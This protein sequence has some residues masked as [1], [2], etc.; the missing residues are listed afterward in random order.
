[1]KS[2]AGEPSGSF[3]LLSEE[4]WTA[5]RMEYSPPVVRNAAGFSERRNGV[6]SVESRQ[7]GCAEADLALKCR[8]AIRWFTARL[9][10]LALRR[11]GFRFDHATGR[12][13]G[14]APDFRDI[15]AAGALS[16]FYDFRHVKWSF[17]VFDRL[18][19]R[20]PSTTEPRAED[21]FNLPLPFWTSNA[22][23]D[24]PVMWL[25]TDAASLSK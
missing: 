23:V 21:P 22:G 24:L 18:A 1:M 10:G 2:G 19:G 25:R 8:L 4:V 14:S 20:G 16:R 17:Q 7:I 15:A 12:G 11:T 9:P 3:V 5:S 13:L 6:A